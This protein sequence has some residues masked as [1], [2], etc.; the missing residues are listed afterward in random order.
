MSNNFPCH[1]LGI[2][3]GMLWS[4][5]VPVADEKRVYKT[6]STI[7]STEASGYSKMQKRK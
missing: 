7:V 1:F 5:F 6:I 2:L 3:F 4:L